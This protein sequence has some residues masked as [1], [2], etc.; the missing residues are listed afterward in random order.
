MGLRLRPAYQVAHET[1][2]AGCDAFANGR[3][4]KGLT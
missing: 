4:V 3:D 2:R 1:G